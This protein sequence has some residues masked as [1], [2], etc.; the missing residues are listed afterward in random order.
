MGNKTRLHHCKT[1]SNDP[2]KTFPRAETNMYDTII[3]INY[4]ELNTP[5]ISAEIFPEGKSI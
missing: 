3:T 4:R 5:F 1:E 2:L